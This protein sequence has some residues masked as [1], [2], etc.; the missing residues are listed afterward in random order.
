MAAPNHPRAVLTHPITVLIHPKAGLTHHRTGPT[1]PIAVL[2]L[3]ILVLTCPITVVTH[4]IAVFTQLMAVLVR[5]HEDR[6]TKNKHMIQIPMIGLFLTCTGNSFLFCA[7]INNIQAGTYLLNR[8]CSYL[9]RQCL[10]HGGKF[11]SSQVPLLAFPS[12]PAHTSRQQSIYF[13]IQMTL[14]HAILLLGTVLS[15]P[16]A[17]L[18]Y[19]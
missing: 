12:P 17:V 10:V 19:H 5:Y 4:S 13:Y 1:P 9:E 6:C 8:K 2:T 3:P 15:L 18:T 7:H 14:T 11:S 16:I